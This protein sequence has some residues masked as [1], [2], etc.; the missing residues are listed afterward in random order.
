MATKKDKKFPAVLYVYREEDGDESYLIC[1]E[2]PED[3]VVTGGKTML[4]VYNLEK[5]VMAYGEARI[6]EV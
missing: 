5:V 4:G 6:E 2:I 1:T 3:T